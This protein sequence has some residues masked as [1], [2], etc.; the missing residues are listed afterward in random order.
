MMQTIQTNTPNNVSASQGVFTMSPRDF[1]YWLQGY[2]ELRDSDKSQTPNNSLTM[3][4]IKVIKKHLEYVFQH[5]VASESVPAITTAPHSVTTFYPYT[6]TSSIGQVGS[7]LGSSS[8][9]PLTVVC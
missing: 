8:D 9:I 1:T 3:E 5:Q 7:I 2:F 4:Q 6:G